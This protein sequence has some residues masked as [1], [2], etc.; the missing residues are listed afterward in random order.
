MRIQFWNRTLG[1]W[2]G[3]LAAAL[4][5]VAGVTF[6]IVN[7]TDKTFSYV[8]LI[9]ILVGVAAE[10]AH[11]ITGVGA[12]RIVTAS[13]F[14]VALG[15][16]L[17]IGL[18]SVSDKLNGVHFVGGD[19]SMVIVFGIVFAVGTVIAVVSSYLPD[20]KSSFEVETP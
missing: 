17:L 5:L 10:V 7:S 1:F 3:F 15:Y 11:I 19:A 20:S 4:M 12:L 9:A 14:G 18:P 2:L 13:S 6:W 16:H 8:T